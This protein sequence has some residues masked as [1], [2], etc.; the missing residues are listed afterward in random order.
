[1]W[2]KQIQLFAFKAP[3][4]LPTDQLAERLSPLE[5]RPCLPSLPSSHGWVSPLE[6]EGAPL[7]RSLNA[8]HL[9]CLQI[10]DKILPASV[11]TYLK[12]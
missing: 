1:M 2:F 5:F 6:E 8:C 10:E 7:V 3:L 9:I 11:I 4:R 12:R